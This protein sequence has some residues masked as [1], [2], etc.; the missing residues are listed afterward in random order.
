MNRSFRHY[1]ALLL[2]L[3]ALP[4][5]AQ[6][7]EILSGVPVVRQ[8]SS[9]LIS[10]QRVILWGVSSLAIDQQCWN[11]DIPWRCGEQALLALRHD[12]ESHS[13]KCLVKERISASEIKGQCFKIKKKKEQDIGRALIHNGWAFA[14]PETSGTYYEPDQEEAQSKHRGVWTSSFQSPEDWKN[15][16]L[17][18]RDGD[19]E[20]PN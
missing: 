3:A 2:L 10:G 18:F 14:D 8:D 16:V 15:G 4:A 5:M 11:E 12:V 13:L 1:L 19:E 6:D 7:G 9:L 17:H 20:K